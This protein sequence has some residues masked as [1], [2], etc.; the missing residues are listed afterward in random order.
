MRVMLVPYALFYL[1]VL[2]VFALLCEIL[3]STPWGPVA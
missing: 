1:V 3:R 2:A